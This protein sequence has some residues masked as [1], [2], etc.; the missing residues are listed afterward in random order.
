MPGLHDETEGEATPDI[1]K[2]TVSAAGNKK[3]SSERTWAHA[4]QTFNTQKLNN[5]TPAS[6]S[7]PTQ[8]MAVAA[9]SQGK[10]KQR[11]WVN[12]S[13]SGIKIIDERSG[14]SFTVTPQLPPAPHSGQL[15]TRFT[16]P[17]CSGD[18]ARACGE[19]DLLHRQ[20]RYRQP[21]LRIRVWGRG[22]ASVC[23]H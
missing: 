12:I 23:R 19:Q 1:L 18:R 21:G 4:V 5:K 15:T 17:L 22:P 13:L 16:V 20:G 9:R 2:M 10:H 7:P 14:V 6:V 11:I 8:G 3:N